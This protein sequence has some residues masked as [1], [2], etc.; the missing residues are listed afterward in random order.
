MVVRES[1]KFTRLGC[2]CLLFLGCWDVGSVSAPVGIPGCQHRRLHDVP[3]RERGLGTSLEKSDI[4]SL[5]HEV[6][7]NAA[8]ECWLC[9]TAQV[10]DQRASSLE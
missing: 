8:W 4:S 5:V 2:F 3:A 7:A 6:E 1:Y 10:L 9:E